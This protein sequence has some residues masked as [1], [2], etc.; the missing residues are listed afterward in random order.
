MDTV[1]DWARGC[2][3]DDFAVAADAVVA[4]ATAGAISVK[5]LPVA[6]A[7]APALPA[8][9]VRT[10][11]VDEGRSIRPG[12]RM[13]DCVGVAEPSTGAAAEPGPAAVVVCGGGAC[14]ACCR[15]DGVLALTGLRDSGLGAD[16]ADADG[17]RPRAVGTGPTKPGEAAS[18]LARPV[19]IPEG[20]PGPA[21]PAGPAVPMGLAAAG[22]AEKGD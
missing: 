15:G 14:D 20:A 22:P 3:V 7:T 2:S 12:R 5:G 21:G 10:E 16:G 13:A 9:I 8:L 4:A 19:G 1:G 18:M 6:A 11:T 17:R